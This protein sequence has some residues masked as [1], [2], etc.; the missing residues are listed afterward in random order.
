MLV[1]HPAKIFK[2]Q[3]RGII[4]TADYKCFPTFNYLNYR[5]EHRNPFGSLKY[6]NEEQLAPQKSIKYTFEEEESIIIIPII[7]AIDIEEHK[8]I[9]FIHIHQIFSSTY[10][11]GETL[12]LTNPYEK[13]WINYIQ[14]RTT[15]VLPKKIG[16][17]EYENNTL[18]DILNT[19][20][21]RISTGLFQDR[22]DGEYILQSKNSNLMVFIINGAFEFQNRL[23]EN[24]DALGIW[25]IEE[26]E[27]ECLVQNGLVL[28][29]ETL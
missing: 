14:I 5:N 24:R 11:A 6:F 2:A 28:L 25:D 8:S 19:E 7:G 3:Q 23:L 9:K 4:S 18:I 16:N 21:I 13:E 29:I 10:N 27:F 1:Q 15:K 12:I 20:G 22:I 26:I 17:F